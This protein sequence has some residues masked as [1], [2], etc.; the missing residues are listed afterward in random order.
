M[1]CICWIVGWWLCSRRHLWFGRFRVCRSVALRLYLCAGTSSS[2][3]RIIHL[4]ISKEKYV[5]I[6]AAHNLQSF[7]SI[8]VH[9]GSDPSSKERPS[10][11]NSSEN[12]YFCTKERN[13][14]LQIT[15]DPLL[16][17]SAKRNGY[18]SQVQY[19]SPVHIL[20]YPLRNEL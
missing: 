20:S 16:Q 8:A 17:M 14:N 7:L 15:L 11:S 1:L 3:M 12:T 5:L 2:A 19:N 10:C 4:W 6:R 13:H 9:L 18:E